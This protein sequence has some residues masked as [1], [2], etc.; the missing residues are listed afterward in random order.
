MPTDRPT[1]EEVLRNLYRV[2]ERLCNAVDNAADDIGHEPLD[3]IYRDLGP[4]TDAA[5]RYLASREQ[6]DLASSEFGLAQM[7]QPE[8]PCEE[9]RDGETEAEI[10]HFCPYN[11]T[12]GPCCCD[13]CE[14]DAELTRLRAENERLR[15]ELIDALID[16]VDMGCHVNDSGKWKGWIDTGASST[17]MGTMDRLV[18]LGRMEKHPDG[19]GRMQFYRW[20]RPDEKEGKK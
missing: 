19:V 13:G 9:A 5:R 10:E 16:T 1:E 15:G 20:L 11:K 18:E 6:P 17:Y 14:A 7:K 2:C 12:E 8:Q 3:A 4:A